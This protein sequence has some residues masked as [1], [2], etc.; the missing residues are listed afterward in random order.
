ML[1]KQ[2]PSTCFIKG[3]KA[4]EFF[5]ENRAGW[6]LERVLRKIG[7]I[8]VLIPTYGSIGNKNKHF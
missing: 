5:F 3:T 6:D 8:Q 4:C 1:S 7:K 2:K